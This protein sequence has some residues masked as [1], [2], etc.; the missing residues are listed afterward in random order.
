M[1]SEPADESP[2]NGPTSAKVP[3]SWHTFLIAATSGLLLWTAFPPV[4]WWW[5]AW[6]APAGWV[7][8]IRQPRW[9]GRHPYRQ[10]YLAA[11]LH[12]LLVIH[13]IR[14][15]HWSAYFGW[16]ALAAYLAAYLPLFV[17]L[18][19]LAVH[20]LRWPTVIVAPAI[21]TGL[22]LIRGH[23]LTGFSMGLLGHTQAEQPTLIQIADVGGA[24]AVAFAIMWVAACVSRFLPNRSAQTVERDNETAIPAGSRQRIA[25]AVGILAMLSLVVGYGKFRLSQSWVDAAVEPVK[26]AL[27]QGSIDTTFEKDNRLEAMEQYFELTR[28]ALQARPDTD[29]VVWPESMY[30]RFWFDFVEPFSIDAEEG[31][32]EEELRSYAAENERAAANFANMVGRPVLVGSPGRRYVGNQVERFNSAQWLEPGAAAKYYHK[33]HPVIFGEY[34]PGGDWFPWLYKLTPM[35]S[36]LTCGTAAEAFRIRTVT[37]CPNIC[38]ENTVPHLIRRQVR[39]LTAAG[40]KPDALVTITNDGWFWGSSQLDFHLACGIMRSVELRRPQFIAANTGFSA[41]IDAHGR[42]LEKGPRHSTGVVWA[43]ARPHVG[44]TSFYE[45]WGDLGP[46]LCVLVCVA[47]A[48]AGIARSVQPS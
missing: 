30:A 36:G 3:K 40:E 43:A 17:G 34:V 8:Q 11:L 22:E 25:A 46:F 32:R 39:D 24:Y 27:I 1:P 48:W 13:W 37:L 9:D 10:L 6:L 31:I 16:L 7:W 2:T 42:V 23:F 33:M 29:L 12:W 19:R 14:L 38:Y 21:W 35:S 45:S 28:E 4:G 44:P 26:I 5:M 15:P 20:R 18:S 47:A 41:A